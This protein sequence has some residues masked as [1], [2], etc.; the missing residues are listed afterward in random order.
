MTGRQEEVVNRGAGINRR[1]QREQDAG[2]GLRWRPPWR[3]E[4]ARP[5]TESDRWADSWRRPGGS[6]FW[7]V[8]AGL[9]LVNWLLSGL[10]LAPPQELVNFSV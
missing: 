7:L 1:E 5:D 3:V 9:L 2:K 10:L 6:R 4:G 8:L